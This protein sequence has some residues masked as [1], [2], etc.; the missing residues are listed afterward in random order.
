MTTVVR[1][2]LLYDPLKCEK[3]AFKINIISV[4][5]RIADTVFVND[6]TYTRENVL[7]VR[8]YDYY[9]KTFSTD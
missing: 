2:C 5:K 1:F 6:V 4:R 9:D 3:T 8:P 7:H